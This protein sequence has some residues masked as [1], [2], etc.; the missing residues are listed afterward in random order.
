[1]SAASTA[2]ARITF[3]LLVTYSSVRFW[4]NGWIETLY[5]APDHHLTYRGFDWVRPLPAGV[6]ARRRRG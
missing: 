2:V 3:G 5:L 1:M 6:D 4:H